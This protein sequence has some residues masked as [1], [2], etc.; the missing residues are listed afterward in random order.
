MSLIVKL[1]QKYLKY[2]LASLRFLKF[3]YVYRRVKMSMQVYVHCLYISIKLL[4]NFH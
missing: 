2:I 4:T 3:E 1:I